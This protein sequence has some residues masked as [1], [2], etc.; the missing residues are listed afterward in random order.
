MRGLIYKNL[1]CEDATTTFII[2]HV[3]Y[4]RAFLKAETN[5]CFSSKLFIYEFIGRVEVI[6]NLLKSTNN[7]VH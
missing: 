6:E 5:K 2:H 7:E 4:Y 3:C 1:R